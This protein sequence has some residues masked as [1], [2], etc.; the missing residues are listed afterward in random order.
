MADPTAVPASSGD[1]QI[2]L[3]SDSARRFR[4]AMC[5]FLDETGCSLGAVIERSGAVIV[6]EQRAPGNGV[7]LPRADAM[8]ALAAGLFATTQML[9]QQIGE[10]EA[11]EVI[12]H[13]RD[14]HLFMAP[15]SAE[16]AVLAVFPN[17]VAVGLIRLQARKLAAGIVADLGRVIRNVTVFAPASGA[18]AGEEREN[19]FLR[20][21]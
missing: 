5:L 17:R 7:K 15:L 1:Y 16:F 19:L 10:P 12:C 4:E 6:T 9:S 18:P 21:N 8:G 13:G 20:Y 2:N 14:L 11:P 3:T